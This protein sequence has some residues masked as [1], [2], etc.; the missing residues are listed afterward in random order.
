MNPLLHIFAAI[1]FLAV[2]LP[3]ATVTFFVF[4]HFLAKAKLR[5]DARLTALKTQ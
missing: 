4:C 5:R 3:A 2:A 1:G